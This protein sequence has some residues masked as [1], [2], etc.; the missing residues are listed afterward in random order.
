MTVEKTA[1]SFDYVI[2]G[3]GTAGCVLANRL[4]ESGSRTVLLIEA[5]PPISGLLSKIPAALDFALH[6]CRFNWCFHTEPEPFMGDRR[7]NCPRGRALGGSS[8]INGMQFVRGNPND[9]DNWASN[10]LDNWDYAHCLPYF[11]RLECYERGGDDY[12]GHDGPLHVSPGSIH[13]PL[14]QAFFDSAS[15]AGHGFSE[16]SNGYRQDGFGLSDKNTYRGRRWSAF[17]AYLKPAI[18]RDNLQV[19]TGCLAYRIIFDNRCAIGIEYKANEQL[20]RALAEKEVLICGGSVNS[21]HLLMLSG[22]GDAEHL[23]QHGIPLLQHLPGVGQNLQDHLDLRIQV[24]CKESVS[25][26]PSTRG[27]GRIAAG[28][29]WLLTRSGVCST[30]LLDVAGYVCSRPELQFPN[31]Q[32]CFMAVAASYDGSKTYEGHGYQT[33]IDLMKPT[34]RG[35]IRLRTSDPEDA[36]MILF[37]YLQTEE[38]R[39]VVVEGF[40]LARELLA[41]SSFDQFRGVELDP[42]D[43]VKSD[44]EILDWVKINGETEYHPTSSCSMGYSDSAVVDNELRVHGTENLRVIDASIMPEIVTANTHATTLMIAEKISD[45]IL[46]KPPLPALSV[47]LFQK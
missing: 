3:G 28:L 45:S 15:Q 26:Y 30:N 5:G 43:D 10:E 11:K 31:L 17:D 39:R 2:V 37:N 36:P 41:Q 21:P 16:D 20:T 19:E 44:K 23:Q 38:D 9:F 42:G 18:H 12:R 46:E 34:S 6:D 13:T 29:Q 4:T 7:M 25:H 8:S 33:H 40:K 35:C 32:L 47:P 1:G 22:I 27:M 24:S 14:D